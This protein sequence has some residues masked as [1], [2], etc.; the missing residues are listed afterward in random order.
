MH[1]RRSL[2]E[3]LNTTTVPLVVRVHG[4]TWSQVA[5]RAQVMIDAFSQHSYTL[6][7]T[8]ETVVHQW[9]CE[10]ADVSIVGGDAWQKF[11]AMARM[12]EY[13]ISVPR[14]PIPL[15]GGM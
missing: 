9:S 10:P 15:Q 12:Q 5:N 11:H 1:G 13:Q 3:V 14:H 8:I 7:V 4:S 6:T 2:G